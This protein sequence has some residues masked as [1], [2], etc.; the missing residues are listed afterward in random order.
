M[1]AELQCHVFCIN[2]GEQCRVLQT[3]RNLHRS[4]LGN[5]ATSTVVLGI[6]YF[7]LFHSKWEVMNKHLK[8]GSVLDDFSDLEGNMPEVVDPL[9]RHNRRSTFRNVNNEYQVLQ[10]DFSETTHPSIKMN[11]NVLTGTKLGPQSSL[12]QT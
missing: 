3:G 2:I 10:V 8:K 4:F 12:L 5:R 1:L 7:Y 9:L 6:S 11:F